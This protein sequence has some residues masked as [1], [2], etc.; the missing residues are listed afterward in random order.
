MQG[1]R[2]NLAQVFSLKGSIA[3]LNFCRGRLKV[4]VT[5]DGRSGGG[6]AGNTLDYQSR[7]CKIDPQLL[8]SLE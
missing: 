1:Y 2:N 4:K 6:V 8:R 5:L 3:I 7:D